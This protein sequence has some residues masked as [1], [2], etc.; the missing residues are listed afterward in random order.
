V[1]NQLISFQFFSHQNSFIKKVFS[2]II[3]KID[4]FLCNCCSSLLLKPKPQ[5]K[6]I[7]FFLE[8]FNIHISHLTLHSM[9]SMALKWHHKNIFNKITVFVK[10][11]QSPNMFFDS[12]DCDYTRRVYGSS[13]PCHQWAHCD[14]RIIVRWCPTQFILIL[15]ATGIDPQ[16]HHWCK[17]L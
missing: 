1:D 11:W 12:F 9:I 6:K 10:F 16:L 13:W 8:F 2:L 3:C 14:L 15:W 7:E 4:Y 17:M 5:K